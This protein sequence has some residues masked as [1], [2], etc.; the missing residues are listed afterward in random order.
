MSCE[1]LH[2]QTDPC[3]VFILDG[4]DCSILAANSP[5][6]EL[7]GRPD[8]GVI[9]G[10]LETWWGPTAKR[11]LVSELARLSEGRHA[12]FPLAV[13]SNDGRVTAIAANVR[14]VRSEDKT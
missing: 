12:T 13:T 5:A 10:Q 11:N 4:N 7:L 9:G 2:F 8:G 3:A 1:T 14:R 6:L